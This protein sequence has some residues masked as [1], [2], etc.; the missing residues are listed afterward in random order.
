MPQF[1]GPERDVLLRVF[2]AAEDDH[3]DQGDGLGVGVLHHRLGGVELVQRTGGV[4][5]AHQHV[6]GKVALQLSADFQ[7]DRLG[8]ALLRLLARLLQPDAQCLGGDL[9]GVREDRPEHGTQVGQAHAAVQAD[10]AL[11]RRATGRDGGGRRADGQPGQQRQRAQE[12]G[13]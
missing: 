13:R 2:L 8:T 9:A 3:V 10:L 12:A 11:P 5:R 4:A 6:I 1:M 7:R